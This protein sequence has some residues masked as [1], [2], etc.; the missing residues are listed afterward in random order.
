M[1]VIITCGPSYEPIDG[2]RRITNA[3]TGELGLMLAESLSSA[4]HEVTVLKGE[5]ATSTNPS[6]NSAVLSF[7]TNDD[8]LQKLSPMKADAV[9]HAAALCDF[10]IK[11]VKNEAGAISKAA[12]IPTKAGMLTLTL[13]PTTKVLPMLRRIFPNAMIVGWKFELDG[14]QTDVLAKAA[15]QIRTCETDAC[16]VNGSAWGN[17]FGVVFKNTKTFAA[18]TR[19]ALCQY[20]ASIL[21]A[22]SI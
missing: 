6:G 8:L 18:L 13:E 10:R 2:M 1:K 5:M 15:E 11:E 17:G 3:S 12:K 21:P 16:V 20:L 22:K 4:G 14:S 19:P 9:F 7:S